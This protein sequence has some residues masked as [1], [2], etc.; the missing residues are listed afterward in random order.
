MQ[1]IVWCRCCNKLI[2]FRSGLWFCKI[3]CRLIGV[4]I[5]IRLKFILGSWKRWLANWDQI[6]LL[7]LCI[8][9]RGIFVIRLG[10]MKWLECFMS[11][12]VSCMKSQGCIFLFFNVRLGW[13]LCIVCRV[14]ILKQKFF[15][16]LCFGRL[17]RWVQLMQRFL[18]QYNWVC[19]FIIRVFLILC[20]SIIMLL[21]FIIGRVGIFCI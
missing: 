1:W 10:S 8:C 11:K 15:I 12:L 19:F 9:I 3:W 6:V 7:F 18:L 4:V 5:E 17:V 16:G 14:F 13:V 2:V 20:S 21:L